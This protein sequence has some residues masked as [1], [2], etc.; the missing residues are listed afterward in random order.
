MSRFL[1]RCRPSQKSPIRSARVVGIP[2]KADVETLILISERHCLGFIWKG[3]P[4]IQRRMQ[5]RK[6]E[7]NL[8]HLSRIMEILVCHFLYK[9]LFFSLRSSISR[10]DAY[11]WGGYS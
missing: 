3:Y 1:D 10:I 6:E 9:A 8:T 4:S 5:L 11:I 2:R 7:I